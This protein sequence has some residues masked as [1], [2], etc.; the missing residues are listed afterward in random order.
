[1]SR[2]KTEPISLL[3]KKLAGSNDA[4]P[5]K[6]PEMKQAIGSEKALLIKIRARAVVDTEKRIKRLEDSNSLHRA[7][8]NA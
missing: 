3:R 5:S 2:Q 1:M 7:A 4:Q 8:Y 6:R